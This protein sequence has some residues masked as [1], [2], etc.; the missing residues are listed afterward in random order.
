M[1]EYDIT[2]RLILSAEIEN[3]AHRGRIGPKR[4]QSLNLGYVHDWA[5][6]NGWGKERLKE[7]EIEFQESVAK[8]PTP[9]QITEAEEAWG[10]L[11]LVPD[12]NK[13]SALAA[14]A[15]CMADN[16]RRFFKDWCKRAGI[17]EKTGRKR[18]DQAI[19]I[20][21]AKLVR[22][23]VQNNET[24]RFEGLP[25]TPE[26]DDQYGRIGN[27]WRFDP[28]SIRQKADDDFTWAAKRNERRRQREA[29]RRKREKVAA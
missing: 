9:Q 1:N 29:Q 18:K 3:A 7:D 4:D 28:Y 19:G 15:G 5:D 26:T 23:D 13:R 25:D 10:W 24:G 14:W 8:R 21:R 22:S 12:Q 11:A 27:A 2:E 20:I 17:S 6:K 16:K